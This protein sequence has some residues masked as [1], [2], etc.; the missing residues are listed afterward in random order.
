MYRILATELNGQ[1]RFIKFAGKEFSTQIK[2][3]AD[4]IADDLNRSDANLIH[5]INYEVVE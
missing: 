1:S 2:S 5:Q 3:M 4:Q